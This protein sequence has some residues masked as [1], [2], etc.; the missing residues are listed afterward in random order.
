MPRTDMD[1]A[2]VLPPGTV[3]GEVELITDGEHFDRVVRDALL[4]AKVSVAIATADVKAMLVPIGAGGEAQS[5]IRHLA[6]MAERGVE[7]RLLHG[8]VPSSE[9]IEELKRIARSRR[10]GGMRPRDA[11]LPAGMVLRRCPRMHAKAVIVDAG[12]MYLGS[13]N[14]TGAG[15]GAKSAARRNFEL[16]VCTRST[17][18]I[19]SVL[20]GFNELWEGGRCGGCGRRAICPA[21]LEEPRV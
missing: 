14:L 3:R 16:G 5:V 18:M 12:W 7:V 17:A 9:A 15:M 11:E 13:A 4:K 8:S 21:P 19:E 1:D 10:R 20:A 6:Q 2:I